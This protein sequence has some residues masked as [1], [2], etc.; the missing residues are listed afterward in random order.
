M[1]KR[2]KNVILGL[3]VHSNQ[4]IRPIPVPDVGMLRWRIP[5]DPREW[6][7]GC[8]LAQ[9]PKRKIGGRPAISLGWKFWSNRKWDFK[10]EKRWENDQG[11]SSGMETRIVG[12]KDQKSNFGKAKNS[13]VNRDWFWGCLIKNLVSSE[14]DGNASK[15]SWQIG[16]ASFDE[17]LTFASVVFA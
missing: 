5:P 11:S 2:L 16:N 1:R 3:K 10:I 9:S 13:F 7:S 4:V 8:S 12:M 17:T 14:L 15:L 6:L